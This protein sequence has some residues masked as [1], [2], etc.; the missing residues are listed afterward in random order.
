MSST[1]NIP[2]AQARGVTTVIM[3]IAGLRA[4]GM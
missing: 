4:T 2:H 1:E 3:D